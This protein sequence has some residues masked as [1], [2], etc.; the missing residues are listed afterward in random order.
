VDGSAAEIRVLLVDDHAIERQGVR[1][2]LDAQPDITV[3][4]EAGD[5]LEALRLVGQWR[6][7]VVITE[8]IM[9]RM[10]GLELTGQILRRY[11][12]LKV[13]VLTRNDREDCVLRLVQAGAGGYLLKTV[14]MADLLAAVRAVVQGGRVLQPMAL[15]TILDDYLQRVREP[16]ARRSAVELTARE[17]EVLKL[18]AEGNTNQDIAD[19]LCLSRKTVETHRGNIMDKLDLHKVTDLVRYAIREGLIGLD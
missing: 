14:D 17:R 4:A 18:I 7:D 16:S 13:L 19:L 11:P 2:L 6:P 1:S 8:T 3:V 12:D 9:P 5:G 10:N 15:E